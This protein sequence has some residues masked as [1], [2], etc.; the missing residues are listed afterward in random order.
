[1]KGGPPLS[2]DAKRWRH[3][4]TRSFGRRK[5]AGKGENWRAL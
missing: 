5:K 2:M 3:L 4:L 1:M